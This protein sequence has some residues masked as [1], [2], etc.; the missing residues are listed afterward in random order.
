MLSYSLVAVGHRADTTADRAD[1]IVSQILVANKG[2]VS[3]KLGTVRMA[4]FA[5]RIWRRGWHK[6]RRNA[7]IASAAFLTRALT[8]RRVLSRITAIAVFLAHSVTKAL[9]I[10]GR[11]LGRERRPHARRWGA[12]LSFILKLDVEIAL[13]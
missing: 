1:D 7:S 8:F 11:R 2:V 3:N 6:A 13:S 5:N 12:R 4:V 10:V 9:G